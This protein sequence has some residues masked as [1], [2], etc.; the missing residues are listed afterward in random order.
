MHETVDKT[1]YQGVQRTLV[2]GMILSFGLMA[3]GLLG[4]VLDPAAGARA[5]EVVPLDR[6]PAAL[7]ALDPAAL[8]D[9]GVLALMFIPVVH[10]AVA[11]LT[12][13]RR[14]EPRYAVAALVVLALLAGSAILAFMRH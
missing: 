1:L 10:L 14:R 7:L 3:L 5:S 12:F 6:L 11:L 8:L 9:L 2:G 4:L 13:V